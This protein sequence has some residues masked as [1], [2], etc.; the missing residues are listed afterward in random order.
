[1]C[2]LRR[3]VRQVL[4]RRQND[5]FLRPS[6]VWAFDADPVQLGDLLGALFA[7][8]ALRLDLSKL[9]PLFEKFCRWA[10]LGR[11][12]CCGRRIGGEEAEASGAAATLEQAVHAEA[13]F[14][15]FRGVVKHAEEIVAVRLSRPIKTSF[16]VL[17][18]KFHTFVLR[19]LR[20]IF[21]AP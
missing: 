10:R 12:A 16:C 14:T 8:F 5:P 18:E 4:N 3:K 6:Q 13:L 9:Q 21:E 2:A 7:Q 11:V 20:N 1:M 15:V 17:H 19:G